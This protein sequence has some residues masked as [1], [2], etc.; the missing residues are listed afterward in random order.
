LL[1]DVRDFGDGCECEDFEDDFEDDGVCGVGGVGCVCGCDFL[2]GI[3]GRTDTA[4]GNFFRGL[5]FL[6]S[7]GIFSHF[8]VS[9]FRTLPSLHFKTHLPVTGFISL[10]SGHLEL[11]LIIHLLFRLKKIYNKNNNI[12]NN[13][14]RYATYAA[15][16]LRCYATY[17]A[18]K[19]S[20]IIL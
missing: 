15:T 19:V 1:D 8:P 11:F 18:T 3:T 12:K 7:V 5:P 2:E 9:L 4:S 20:L 10:F 13:R 17:A 14:C 16:L 6:F